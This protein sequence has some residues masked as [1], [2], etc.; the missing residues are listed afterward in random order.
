MQ[1][2]LAKS[3]KIFAYVVILLMIVGIA[4]AGYISFRY[5]DGIGV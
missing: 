1:G 4:Y 5:F 3:V 2:T